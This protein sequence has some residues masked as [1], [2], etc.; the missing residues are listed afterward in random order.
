MRRGRKVYLTKHIEAMM[1]GS[2]DYESQHIEEIH[3]AY[4]FH[5]KTHRSNSIDK[6]TM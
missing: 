3:R 5:D 1:E 4:I 6:N 2:A